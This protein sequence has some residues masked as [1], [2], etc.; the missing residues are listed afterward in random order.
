MIG[1]RLLTV[2]GYFVA[3]LLWISSAP[4]WIVVAS[5]VD[6]LRQSRGVALRSA[7]FVAV[8]LSCEVLGILASGLLWA[9]NLTWR[10]DPERWQDLHFALEA[11][12][13]RTLLHSV[14]FL[15]DLKLEVE[16]TALLER[17]PYLLLTRHASAGDTLLASVFAS[18]A[19]GIRLRYVLKKELLWDPCLDIVGHRV[20]NAF[21]DRNSDDSA[22]QVRQVKRLAEGL[23]PK[24]GVLIYPEGSRFTEEKRSRTIERFKR[25]GNVA[26][27]EYATELTHALS[28]RPGGVLGLLEQAREADVVICSHTG[29]ESAASISQIWN[30][31]LLGNTVHVEYRRIPRENIPLDPDAQAQWLL[32]E[33]KKVSAYVSGHHNQRKD[34]E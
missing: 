23:G 10:F 11:W 1:R 14:V 12:W 3:W 32:N 17:G 21:V 19:F 8:Y 20:P 29:F 2:P 4:V 5:L 33:W 28:P 24:D 31:L 25:Q 13:A 18:S 16:G 27:Q 9:R 6:L 34:Q 26:M 7:T 15:F 22:A 30:G